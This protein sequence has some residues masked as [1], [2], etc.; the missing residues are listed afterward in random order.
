MPL[1]TAALWELA[2]LREQGILS[3]DEFDREKAKILSQKWVPV[4]AL[5]AM[6]S[7]LQLTPGTP[8]TMSRPDWQ[9]AQERLELSSKQPPRPHEFEEN[10]R[11]SQYEG[12]AQL[13]HSRWQDQPL[14]DGLSQ[15]ERLSNSW[16]ATVDDQQ[17]T[18]AVQGL[19]HRSSSPQPPSL[20]Q[21]AQQQHM[22]Q[23]AHK[24]L[25]QMPFTPSDRR[26]P[27]YERVHTA[28]N[29]TT[30]R[31]F[32]PRTA[33]CASTVASSTSRPAPA[34]RAVTPP[35]MVTVPSTPS[36]KDTSSSVGPRRSLS[37]TPGILVRSSG[38]ATPMRSLATPRSRVDSVVYREGSCSPSLSPTMVSTLPTPRYGS[39]A[40]SPAYL[41]YA[42]ECACQPTRV[43]GY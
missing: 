33:V 30:P 8:H 24:L 21:H 7:H 12:C 26:S 41:R 18:S 11:S 43:V 17:R 13:E 29:S 37:P 6:A 19:Y 16:Q 32:A 10:V 23:E 36:A 25:A 1:D 5:P 9:E 34:R 39:R 35:P 3:Q 27:G 38:A 42:V 2:S 28:S 20:Q 31:S 22:Q 15:Q 4:D 40:E 14:Q